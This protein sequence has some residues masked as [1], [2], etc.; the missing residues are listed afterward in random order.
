M[1]DEAR[2][3]GL[4]LLAVAAGVLVLAVGL[5]LSGYDAAAAFRA[6]AEGA[7]GSWRVVTDATLLRA[8]PLILLGLSFALA[9]RGG[10]LN[11][12]AEGQFYAGAIVATWVGLA[13]TTWPAWL[14]LPAVAVG[15]L[16]GGALWIVVPVVL[17]L[18]FGVLE[19]ITT[20][21][22]NFVA[23]ALVSLMVQGPLQ[24]PSGIYPQS[25]PIAVA[26]RLPLLGGS[27]LHA[28]FLVT[29]AVAGLLA[30]VLARTWWG[31]RLR[32]LGAG[33]R[34]AWVSG[35]VP[36]GK[37]LATSLLLSGALAGLAGAF[38][39][40]GVSYALYQNLSPGY[41]F[42]AI[43]VALLARLHPLGI[44]VSGVAF[45]ALEAGGAAMQRDAGIPAVT[46]HVVEAVIIVALLLG[47][48]ALRRRSA[49]AAEAGL[50]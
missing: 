2:A 6:L 44:L 14:A 42:T 29:L 33:P 36:V 25:A 13:A 45:G 38:E 15:G 49:R 9:L 7:F 32:A 30:W 19:V 5:T 41:G 10:A 18:R 35:R 20:I 1:R 3:L 48:V 21:L 11:I 16:V 46:V 22:L 28:G 37:F 40:S 23:D 4:A 12:G 31:F 47:D 26:A 27:R 34:A 39:V 43:G 50:A 17:R 8:T 24:E